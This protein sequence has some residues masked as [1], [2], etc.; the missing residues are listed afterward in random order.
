MG[1]SQ[2]FPRGVPP[3]QE[4]TQDCEVHSSHPAQLRH[5]PLCGSGDTKDLFP[6]PLLRDTFQHP[7]LSLPCCLFLLLCSPENCNILGVVT[8]DGFLELFR[9]AGFSSLNLLFFLLGCML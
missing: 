8:R 5:Q 4:K 1:T 9:R 7:V 3:P 2:G 6:G